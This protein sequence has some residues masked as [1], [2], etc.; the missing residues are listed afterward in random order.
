MRDLNGKRVLI[1]GGASGIGLALGRRFAREGAAV[2]VTDLNAGALEGAV[3]EVSAAGRPATGLRL[4]VT[5][6]DDIER[7]RAEVLAA[8]PLDVLVNNAGVVFG[9]PFGEVPLE[10]HLLTYRVNVLGVLGMTHAFLP[11]LLERP[12]AHLVNVASASGYIGLPYG[13]T[14]AS[15]KWAVIGLTES[16]RLELRD[17]GRRHVGVTTVCPSYVATGLFDGV[18]PPF[19]TRLLTADRVADLTVRAVRAGKR[20]VLAPWLVKV[21]PMLKGLLPEPLFYTV[22]GLLGATSGMTTWKGRG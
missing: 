3:R 8:G 16:L 22:A 7:V 12:E 11:A 20:T 6:R 2:V 21:T 1:T 15:S 13:T 17:Q 4:D 10:R 9:G 18:R 19:T 5:D 14:Y